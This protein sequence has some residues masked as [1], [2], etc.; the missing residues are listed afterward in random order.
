VLA[1]L[2]Y[3]L[4]RELGA[5]G[6]EAKL[7][8]PADVVGKTSSAA[9]SELSSDGFT[10]VVVTTQASGTVNANV[11]IS[12]S[13][14]G[15]S[16]VKHSTQ[17]TLVVSSGPAPVGVP[18]VASESQ[19]A[20][21]QAL[22]AKGFKVAVAQAASTSVQSGSVISTSPAAGTSAARG[23]TVTI[24]VSTGVPQVTIPSVAGDT[25]VTASN[26]LN[27]LGL[28]PTQVSQSSTTVKAGY[29]IGTN[30]AAGSMV[31][32][33]STV[34]IYVSTGQP[35]ATIPSGLIGDT[36]AEAI[37][38]LAA[39]GFPAPSV[40]TQT[41]S[42][43]SQDG[44]VLSASP[45]PGSTQPQNTVV[46]LVV[47]KYTV[48]TATVPTVTGQSVSAAE[49]QLATA[50]FTDVTT[51]TVSV[52]DPSQNGLAQSTN[53]AGGTSTTTNTPITLYVGSYSGTTSSTSST[54]STTG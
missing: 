11:V 46:T 51:Q 9:Q 34:E 36:E 13:P 25:P 28:N 47:G 21:T 15:G 10:N 22:Q 14:A 32:T 16:K 17:V 30:P 6:G 7:T 5:W 24:T 12:T 42:M 44:T 54:S 18:N 20:A 3:F 53:P 2:V 45:S 4:G 48:P 1:G 50:G 23:S 29:V 49:S 40:S 43:Q 41:V 26:Q 35:T 37:Q 38:Q 19:A 33:S 52:S 31:G 39:A 8:V 27:A